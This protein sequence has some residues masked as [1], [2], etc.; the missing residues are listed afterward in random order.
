MTIKIIPITKKYRD[1]YERIFMACAKG[2]K[3][4]KKKGK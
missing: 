1:N 2:N 3:K 4:G